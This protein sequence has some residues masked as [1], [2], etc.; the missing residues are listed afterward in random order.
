MRIKRVIEDRIAGPIAEVREDKLNIYI[1]IDI[2]WLTF[3]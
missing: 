1:Y 2:Q 3:L